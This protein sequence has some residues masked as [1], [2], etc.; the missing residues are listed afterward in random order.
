MRYL[1]TNCGEAF[2]TRPP[3]GTCPRCGAAVHLEP[4]STEPHHSEDE[5]PPPRRR[6]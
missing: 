5:P 2:D 6:L 1:C 3:D 4:E